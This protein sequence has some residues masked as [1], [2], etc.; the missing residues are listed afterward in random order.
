VWELA[1]DQV[2]CWFYAINSFAPYFPNLFAHLTEGEHE[3]AARFVWNR[4]RIQYTVCRA[5]LRQLL[6][7]YRVGTPAHIKFV[8]SPRGKPSLVADLNPIDLQFN[9][10]HSS[11]GA[12]IAVARGCQVGVDIERI[13]SLSDLGSLVRVCFA[14][15]EQAEF[16]SLP[17]QE[18]LRVF[19]AG[20]TRKE[21]FVK[22]IGE[23]LGR[24]FASFSVSLAL[25]TCP[26]VLRLDHDWAAGAAWTLRDL[27]QD[28]VYAAAVAVHRPGVVVLTRDL[29]PET[30][31][32]SEGEPGAEP[33]HCLAIK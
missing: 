16:W 33:P 5:V 15:D 14:P 17:Q 19:F 1:T 29:T 24:S 18:R 2:H 6:A 22:A 11:Q 30:F 4:D 21:A 26:K 25:D 7:R 20:W 32:L 31:G 8:Y 13:R 27:T 12:I 23:G 28:N 9:L 3:R 10:A